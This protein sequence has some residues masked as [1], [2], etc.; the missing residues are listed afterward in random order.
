MR[1]S[2]PVLD[3]ETARDGVR[4]AWRHGPPFKLQSRIQDSPTATVWMPKKSTWK[5][6]ITGEAAGVEAAAAG[7]RMEAS[8]V[9]G[10]V[11]DGERLRRAASGNP[12]CLISGG[13]LV[14]WWLP[15][16]NLEQRGYR[17]GGCSWGQ[18]RN[19]KPIV[20]IEGF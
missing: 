3:T 9:R 13:H 18:K 19:F 8:A 4:Y 16:S 12:L 2:P 20:K 14:W 15:V 17:L 5:A 7:V 1:C 10:R 6:E 11:G